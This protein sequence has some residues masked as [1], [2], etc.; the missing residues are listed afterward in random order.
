MQIIEPNKNYNN[1]T[2]Y[3]DN[4]DNKRKKKKSISINDVLQNYCRNHRSQTNKRKKRTNNR[5]TG[6]NLTPKLNKKESRLDGMVVHKSIEIFIRESLPKLAKELGKNPDN[7]QLLSM[8]IEEKN[9]CIYKA[10]KQFLRNN[11]I[12]K[13]SGKKIVI[14]ANHAFTNF[15]INFSN[16]YKSEKVILGD[17][18]DFQRF[19]YNYYPICVEYLMR[20]EYRGVIVNFKPDMVRDKNGEIILIDFKSG[21]FNQT[22]YQKYKLQV[23]LFAWC[24]EK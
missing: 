19:I 10:F 23:L 20:I 6:K 12:S 24:F 8:I 21:F 2:P 11:E 4:F 13:K 7:D 14:Y 22:D 1:F 9:N 3:D 5:Y 15:L 18:F 17:D 16:E